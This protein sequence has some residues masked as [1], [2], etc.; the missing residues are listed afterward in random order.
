MADWQSSYGKESDGFAV[1]A[2]HQTHQESDGFAVT[3]DHMC[4]A[5][6]SLLPFCKLATACWCI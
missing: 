3:A 6:F 4:N 2:G 5:Q 1:T